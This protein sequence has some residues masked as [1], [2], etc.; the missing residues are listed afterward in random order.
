MSENEME[1]PNDIH[2]DYDSPVELFLQSTIDKM[3]SACADFLDNGVMKAVVNAGFNINKEKLEQV[4]SQDK[5][6]YEEAYRRGYA[7]GYTK[8][9]DEIIRCRDCKH[10]PTQKKCFPDTVCPCQCSDSYY[11]WAP[12]DDWYCADGEPKDGEAD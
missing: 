10:R 5:C 1:I 3:S 9:E 8:R 7:A 2:V 6:R 12:P 4:L 11:S